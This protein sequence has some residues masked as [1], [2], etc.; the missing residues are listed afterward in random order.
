MYRGKGETKRCNETGRVSED[1]ETGSDHDP[2]ETKP[3]YLVIPSP[4]HST[5]V[6]FIFGDK[7]YQGFVD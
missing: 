2:G 6:R 3:G 5:L 7:T 1:K 4:T